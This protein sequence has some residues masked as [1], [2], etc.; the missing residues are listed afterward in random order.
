MRLIKLETNHDSRSQTKT[1]N[2][3]K[4][5]NSKA[6]TSHPKRLF[7]SFN[8]SWNQKQLNSGEASRLSSQKCYRVEKFSEWTSRKKTSIISSWK[9]STEKK[10]FL[11]LSS[12]FLSRF[13]TSTFLMIADWNLLFRRQDE[14]LPWHEHSGQCQHQSS[15]LRLI[16]STRIESRCKSRTRN[17]IR[18]IY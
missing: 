9:L 13:N 16:V 7:P 15:G 17:V 12:F 2:R 18:S 14:T 5:L 3:I 1:L 10:S 8:N 4:I 11:D 6:L